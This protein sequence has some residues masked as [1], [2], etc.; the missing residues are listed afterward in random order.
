MGYN[1]YTSFQPVIMHLQT[2][3]IK[4]VSQ[5]FSMRK[6][7]QCQFSNNNILKISAVIFLP[8]IFAI[9]FLPIISDMQEY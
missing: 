4:K 5:C 2:M 8:K 9:P 3:K 7:Q 6:M 1:M